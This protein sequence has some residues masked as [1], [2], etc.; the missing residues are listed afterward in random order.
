[1]TPFD[2]FKETAALVN[3]WI[4]EENLKLKDLAAETV[5]PLIQRMKALTDS[6]RTNTEFVTACQTG[7]LR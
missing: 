1:M 6:V 3:L 4:T 2:K 7:A 5:R